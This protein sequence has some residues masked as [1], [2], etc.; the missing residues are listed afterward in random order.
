[1]TEKNRKETETFKGEKYMEQGMIQA[2]NKY[3]E[4]HA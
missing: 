2:R 3:C 4:S 1:M